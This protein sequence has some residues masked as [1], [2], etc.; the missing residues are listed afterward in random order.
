MPGYP[1]QQQP[2]P[3]YPPQQQPQPAYAPPQPA[4]GGWAAGVAGA[5][6]GDKSGD[7]FSPAEDGEHIVDIHQVKVNSKGTGFIVE[8]DI[9]Q[10][11]AVRVGA[12]KSWYCNLGREAGQ[13]DTLRFYH[14]MLE[15][16]LGAQYDARAPL[17][18]ATIAH[19]TSEAQPFA[20][21][22]MRLRTN[23][24]PQKANPAKDFTHHDWDVVGK[25][26]ELGPVAPAPAPAAAPGFPAAA[27]APAPAP[28]P[29][30]A[31]FA[32]QMPAGAQVAAAPPAAAP[33][34]PP[35]GWPPHVPYPG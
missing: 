21:Y 18:P 7:Y 27:P 20:G 33:A 13:A 10:S 16:L 14:T 30:M 3:A 24:R 15:H 34:A 5:T 9:V 25:A 28:G 2:Q 22:R 19:G 26:A 12:R 11:D 29:T 1:H 17:D 4:A 23:T 31:P 8:V 6:L 35:P 32:P